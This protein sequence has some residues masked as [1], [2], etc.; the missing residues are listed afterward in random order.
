LRILR[1]VTLDDKYRL[2]TGIIYLSGSQAL[3]RLAIN[4]LWRDEAARHNTAAY[5]TG[6]RGSPMHNVDKESWRATKEL[7]AHKVFFHAAINEDL[8]ATA[9]WGTQQAAM[10]PGGKYD[11]VA[12]MWYGKGPGFDRSIDAIRHANLAG[13]AKLGGVLAAVGDDPA[14]KSTDVPAASETMF[15]DLCMPILY[16]ATVQEMLDFGIFGRGMSRARSCLVSLDAV[17]VEF[18][19]VHPAVAG[20]HFLGA[21]WAAGLDE[22]KLRDR[23]VRPSHAATP[24]LCQ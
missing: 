16:P 18:H 13:T 5:I 24:A 22:A 14:M 23:S 1:E 12:A 17:A 20:G 8:A 9:C 15:A 2:K 7:E 21:D 19:L 3:I 10:Y 4:Q 6:Y 11:G